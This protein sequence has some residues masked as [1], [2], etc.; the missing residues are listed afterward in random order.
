M[1][2]ALL[3]T[4]A[5]VTQLLATVLPIGSSAVALLLNAVLLLAYHRAFRLNKLQHALFTVRF[6]RERGFSAVI[7]PLMN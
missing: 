2:S 4:L 7:E 5:D 6:A 3:K 1:P